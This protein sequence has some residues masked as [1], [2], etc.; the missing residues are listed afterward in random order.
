[1]DTNGNAYIYI[2]VFSV[3]SEM[4]S[5]LCIVPGV[6]PSTK[7][8]FKPPSFKD[9]NVCYLLYGLLSMENAIYLRH[10][11]SVCFFLF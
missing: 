8:L 3:L 10:F 11:F 1:M 5:S 4:E 6:Y 7:W 2:F 9:V